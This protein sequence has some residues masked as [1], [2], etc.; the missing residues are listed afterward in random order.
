MALKLLSPELSGDQR[1]RARFERESRL[2]A[3]IDH[4]GIVPVY[5]AGDADGLPYIAMRY[6]D[7]SDLA[8]L[9]RREG[10]LEPARAL[11]LVGQLAD[12][13]DAAHAR[14]LIHRDV[15]PSNA[16]VARE[17]R[18]VYLADFGLTKTSGPDPVTAS[19]EM[20]GTVA[21]MAPEVIR[22]EEPAPASDLYALGCVLFECLT[23]EVPYPGAERG[24]GHLRAPG[25]AAAGVVPA[26]SCRRVRPG[27]RAGAGQGP[28][29]AVRVGRG[30]GGRGARGARRWRRRPARAAGARPR[31]AVGAAAVAVAAAA[32]AA[33][34]AG[35]RHEDRDDPR[36]TPRR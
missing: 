32:V 17:G 15:K 18:H 30:D 25:A 10:P 26:R 1:F 13:L 7:G 8:Q 35:R 31:R 9:L 5:E 34:V 24:G 22:G 11:E 27:D 4:A 33:V 36:P 14:G 6:V 20:M 2:A 29:R 23:G 16:L 19:G 12:A 3:S 28:G 21:Y